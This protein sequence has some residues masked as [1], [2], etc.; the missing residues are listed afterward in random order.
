MFIRWIF[1]A[2][3]LLTFGLGLVSILAR[4]RALRETTNLSDLKRVFAADNLWGLAA[5][6]WLGTG[7]ARVFGDMEK[8]STYYGANGVFWLKM[9]LFG[10]VFLLE[11][12]PMAT[13][14]RWR[15]QTARK[16]VPN[17]TS[18]PTFASIGRIQAVLLILIV[19][20]ATAMARG[21]GL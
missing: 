13:L 14:I 15:I 7:L 4:N 2:A 20:A 11:I 10:L 17:L 19:L 9:V 8:G 5:L 3:H 21:Y 1:A 12:W 16:Q 6:L 18:A